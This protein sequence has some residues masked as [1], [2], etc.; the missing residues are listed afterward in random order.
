M[1]R[2]PKHPGQKMT[3]LLVS[4]VCDL[5]DPPRQPVTVTC[6]PVRG[7]TQYE[8]GG[9]R[10]S[11]EGYPLCWTCGLVGMNGNENEFECSGG[12][13]TAWTPVVNVSKL[14]RAFGGHYLWV[15]PP[16]WWKIS[17]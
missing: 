9:L 16:Q 3:L 10:F 7:P 13:K 2:C 4:Y 12:H 8:V 1:R 6:E 11:A 15:G 14:K 5:C 17:P